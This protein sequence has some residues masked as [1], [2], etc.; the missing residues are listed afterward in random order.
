M[1][2]PFTESW[3]A[4]AKQS[5]GKGN[6]Y[7]L[8]FLRSRLCGPRLSPATLCYLFRKNE[9][10]PPSASCVGSHQSEPIGVRA[11]V[12]H[13]GAACPAQ[14]LSGAA[15]GEQT[16]P[17]WLL[18]LP[19]FLLFYFLRRKHPIG[20]YLLLLLFLGLEFNYPWQQ[21]ASVSNAHFLRGCHF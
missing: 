8:Y 12:P 4:V 15:S 18:S 1:L 2:P 7:L 5:E 17:S 6:R 20:I 3:S 19:A 10:V 13:P 21:P 9:W 16:K 11:A 14:S